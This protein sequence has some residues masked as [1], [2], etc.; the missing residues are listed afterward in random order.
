MAGELGTA[1]VR[2][3][4]VGS[5]FRGKAGVARN[6][7]AGRREAWQARPGVDRAG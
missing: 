6:G 5:A 2:R 7:A 4:K 3:D 1:M